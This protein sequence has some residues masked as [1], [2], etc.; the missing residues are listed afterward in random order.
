MKAWPLLHES[1]GGLEAE[2]E[3][4]NPR[5]QHGELS[6]QCLGPVSPA[7]ADYQQSY[8]IFLSLRADGHIQMK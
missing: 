6:K 3:V 1:L 8:N 4:P 5:A 2:P 7:A